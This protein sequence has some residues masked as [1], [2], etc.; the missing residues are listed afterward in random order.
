MTW[1]YTFAAYILRTGGPISPYPDKSD[2]VSPS[3]IA[4]VQQS[5]RDSLD[6]LVLNCPYEGMT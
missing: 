6:P 1:G 5:S 4:I 3:L 2:W